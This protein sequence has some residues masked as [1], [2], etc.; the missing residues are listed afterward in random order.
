METSF[1]FFKS[2]GI[3]IQNGKTFLVRFLWV[4]E[5]SHMVNCYNPEQGRVETLVMK[6]TC[7]ACP[8]PLP[9]L[10]VMGVSAECEVGEGKEKKSLGT[11][12][13]LCY[14]TNIFVLLSS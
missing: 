12:Q 8:P 4:S 1:S 10:G 5:T 2:F 7:C 6:L 14:F 9:L 3:I 13:M 11:R